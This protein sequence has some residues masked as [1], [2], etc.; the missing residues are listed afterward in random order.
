M[1][2]DMAGSSAAGGSGKGEEYR[3]RAAPDKPALSKRPG[4]GDN[5]VMTHRT[6]KYHALALVLATALAG[7]AACS[8]GRDAT[9][10]DTDRFVDVVVELRRAAFELRGDPATFELRRDSIL[11]DAG[12]TED[13][14]RAYV[15]RHG[16]DLEHMAEVWAAIN[17]RLAEPPPEVQ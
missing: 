4:N 7:A 17:T 12:V 3:T 11:D 6:L 16:T 8:P 14:L 10:I 5:A 1:I 13:Q 15:E 2:A 9:G